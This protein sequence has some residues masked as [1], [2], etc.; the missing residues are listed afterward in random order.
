MQLKHEMH[1]DASIVREAE[2]AASAL[3]ILSQTPHS[4]QRSS[5]ILTEYKEDP[6][7]TER[8]APTGQRVLQKS[9]PLLAD[10]IMIRTKKGNA[11][12][13]RR[14]NFISLSGMYTENCRKIKAAAFTAGIIIIRFIKRIILPDNE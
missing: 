12:S 10:I 7:K 9:L 6:E 14:L 13:G 1:F 3:H 11:A 2:S 5:R 4:V 8:T